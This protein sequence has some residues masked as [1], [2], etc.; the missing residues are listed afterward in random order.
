MIRKRISLVMMIA[1]FV[2]L[3]S[4]PFE[5]LRQNILQESFIQSYENKEYLTV[6]IKELKKE[7]A[8]LNQ[9]PI[10]DPFAKNRQPLESKNDYALGYIKIPKIGETLPLYVGASIENLD[11]GVAQITGTALPMS[12]KGTH[13]YV[14]G[15]R[16]MEQSNMFLFIDQLVIGDLIFLS[17]LDQE[18]VYAVTGNEIIYPDEGGKLLE[19][20]EKEEL[21]SLLTCHPFPTNRLR[22]LVHSKRLSDAEIRKLGKVV[23]QTA[24]PV[25][26]E[27]IAAESAI[28]TDATEANWWDNATTWGL[29]NNKQVLLIALLT[30]A[31]LTIILIVRLLL[32]FRKNG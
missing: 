10:K 32:T 1:G 27:N 8:Q 13:T 17:Y 23:S 18:A 4:F 3:S 15:H 31:L 21:L 7:V 22:L 30:L 9:G 6:P 28:T 25:Q 11:H 26:F 12:G 24:Q 14:A 20:D 29:K 5:A 16:M 19:V 2:I